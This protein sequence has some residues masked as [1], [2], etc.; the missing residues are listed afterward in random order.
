MD[1]GLMVETKNLTKTFGNFTA[2][3]GINLAV[4]KGTIHGFVGPMGL[5][6]QPL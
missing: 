3:D 5:G 2:V 6:R 4:R 1:N